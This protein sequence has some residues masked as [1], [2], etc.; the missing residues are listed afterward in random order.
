MVVISHSY[1]MV[2]TTG[3]P[4]AFYFGGYDTGGGFGVAI[5]F[6]I[7]GYLVSQS[8]L[9]HSTADYFLSRVLRIVPALFL[10]TCVEVLVIGPTFTKLSLTEYFTSDLTWARLWNPAVFTITY[11][12]PGVFTSLPILGVNGSLWTLPIECSFYLVLPIIAFF[13]ALSH[14]GSLI[15]AGLSIVGYF[16]AVTFFGLGWDAAGPELVRGVSLYTALRYA[17]FFILGAA[18]WVNR[19]HVPVTGGG[20]LLCCGLLFAAVGAPARVLLYMLCLPYLVVYIATQT[21]LVPVRKIG[22]LSYGLFL[23]AFP[24]QQALQ[25]TFPHIGPLSLTM[26]ATAIGL[27]AAYA[28]Y[29][30]VEARF[31]KLRKKRRPNLHAVP[32]NG[33][34]QIAAVL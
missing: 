27:A 3:D 13:G 30:M 26:A 21:P 20:A 7:S 4:F 19:E 28:S 10:V 12:L 1:G 32:T 6:V 17:V 2:T 29:W 5:F 16:V 25:E 18:L 33:P 8:V 15:I 23:F 24:I 14:R 11:T 9:R 22:D 31:L 34:V